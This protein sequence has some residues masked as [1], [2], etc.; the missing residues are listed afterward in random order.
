MSLPELF[1]KLND[2]W[3]A[4]ETKLIDKYGVLAPFEWW[5]PTPD[6]PEEEVEPHGL[7]FRKL[8]GR[9]RICEVWTDKED[10]ICH[11]AISDTDSQ[12]RVD[13][14]EYLPQL[15]DALLEENKAALIRIEKAGN[16]LEAIVRDL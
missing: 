16:R 7:G 4:A 14:I 11:R 15:R 2:Q 6:A 8:N 13:L 12:T 3:A 9:W 1:E 10:E 5:I